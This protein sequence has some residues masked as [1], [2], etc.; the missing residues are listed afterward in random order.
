MRWRKKT[1]AGEL[2]NFTASCLHKTCCYHT[3]KPEYHEHDKNNN[4]VLQIIVRRSWFTLMMQ[5]L[6]FK[7]FFFFK[8]DYIFSLK[9]KSKARALTSHPEN[10]GTW[11]FQSLFRPRSLASRL[12]TGV[13]AWST[14]NLKLTNQKKRMLIIV[15]RTVC[16]DG[17]SATHEQNRSGCGRG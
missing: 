16:S 9:E 5:V 2:L 8:K 12:P 6:Y 1:P 4:N 13:Q 3:Q 7:S 10:R 11:F 14:L 15:F 17:W